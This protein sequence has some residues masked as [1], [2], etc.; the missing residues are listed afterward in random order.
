MNEK[1]ANDVKLA[2]VKKAL[3]MD[4]DSFTGNNSPDSTKDLYIERSESATPLS[5]VML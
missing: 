4:D 2:K 5:Q 3:V 1:L